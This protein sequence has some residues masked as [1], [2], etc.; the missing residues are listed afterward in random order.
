MGTWAV[1]LLQKLLA[2]FQVL[3]YLSEVFFNLVVLFIQSNAGLLRSVDRFPYGLE[4]DINQVLRS[5]SFNTDE[6]D[7]STALITLMA[8]IFTSSRYDSSS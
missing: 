5:D 1:K 2:P 7:V 4:L 8:I 6:T 3:D